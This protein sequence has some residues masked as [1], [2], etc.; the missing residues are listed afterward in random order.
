VG[1]DGEPVFLGGA[2]VDRLQGTLAPG[3]P[4]VCKTY[5]LFFPQRTRLSGLH[6]TEISG[7]ADVTW[8][9]LTQSF[10]VVSGGAL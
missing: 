2:M 9:F 6:S 8:P 3:N 10:T 1:G 5:I 7:P 4:V